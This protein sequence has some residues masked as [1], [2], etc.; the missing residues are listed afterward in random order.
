[1]I[2]EGITRYAPRITGTDVTVGVVDV[3]WFSGRAQLKDLV[4][5]NPDGFRAPSAVE[6]PIAS[7]AVQARSVL[8]K[9]LVIHSIEIE[10]PFITYERQ[11]SGSNLTD[12]QS[13]IEAFAARVKDHLGVGESHGNGKPDHR[14][15]GGKQLQV[16]ELIIRGAQVKL[17]LTMLG[18]RG[19]TVNL[20]DIRLRDLGQEE[21]ITGPELFDIV[22]KTV[23]KATL[24]LTDK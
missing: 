23:V 20:P 3:A 10:R 1:M 17:A 16:D 18:G 7:V 8:R 6:I 2:R 11:L 4:I 14:P 22:W 13:N 12:I 9:K 5:G 24:R 15:T 21:G 19:A